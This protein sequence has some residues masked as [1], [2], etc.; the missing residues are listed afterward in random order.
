MKMEPLF[1]FLASAR[2]R[3][4]EPTMLCH[5]LHGD[6]SAK[7]SKEGCNTPCPWIGVPVQSNR[8]EKCLRGQA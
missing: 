1:K 2:V 5:R 6:Q 4:L 3:M 8:E 7:Q